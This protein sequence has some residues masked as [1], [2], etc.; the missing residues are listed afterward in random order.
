MYPST[1]SNNH[2]LR[3]VTR[4][5]LVATPA[6]A[7]K[8]LHRRVE[9]PARKR[10]G[11]CATKSVYRYLKQTISYFYTTIR[12]T[13]VREFVEKLHEYSQ[14]TIG[15][16]YTPPNS[17][18]A[19]L[20]LS[21]EEAATLVA[22]GTFLNDVYAWPALVDALAAVLKRLGGGAQFSEANPLAGRPPVVACHLGHI[23]VVAVKVQEHLKRVAKF[24]EQQA[25]MNPGHRGPYTDMLAAL[26]AKFILSSLPQQGVRLVDG[27]D[28]CRAVVE[29][30]G[31]DDEEDDEFSTDNSA[32]DDGDVGDG[33][34]DGEGDAYRSHC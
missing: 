2:L 13:A 32:D 9:F 10:K 33:D 25:G 11:N 8:F 20:I 6:A 1:K 14:Q 16:M 27:D 7:G 26:N 34:D 12:L 31:S 5:A 18:R 29:E 15:R 24:V 17:T 23:A 19:H 3:S 4:M 22:G 21:Q 28:A 30:E